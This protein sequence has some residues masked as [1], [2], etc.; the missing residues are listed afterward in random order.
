MSRLRVVMVSGL[1]GAGKGAALRTLEDI[2]YYCIDNLPTFLLPE[3]LA[4]V[5]ARV[6]GP[7]RLAIGMDLRDASFPDSFPALLPALRRDYDLEFLFIEADDAALLRRFSEMR[8]PHPL[9]A[10][11]TVRDGIARERQLLAGVRPLA[12]CCIDTSVLPPQGLRQRLRERFGEDAVAGEAGGLRV[13]LLSFGFKHGVPMEADLLFDARFLPN[14]H[15]VPD[16]RPHTGREP[17][18]AAFV[19]DHDE[20]RRFLDLLGELL[21]FLIPLYR[22]EDKATLTI[23]IGCTGGRHRSVAVA[24]AVADRLAATVI[25]PLVV[26]R[27]LAGEAER[28][29]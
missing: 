20:A 2:G 4:A 10:D 7:R 3:L 15:Y 24:E 21:A 22:R 29:G 16:L 8:R 13:I 9:A 5:A 28:K 25:T 23:G 18:V 19:L 17:E 26:H 12:D 6:E 14:P 11:T 27:E 1:A